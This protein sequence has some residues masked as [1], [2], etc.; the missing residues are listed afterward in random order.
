MIDAASPEEIAP[1]PRAARVRQR[2]SEAHARDAETVK[3]YLG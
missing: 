1:A 3:K 2:P